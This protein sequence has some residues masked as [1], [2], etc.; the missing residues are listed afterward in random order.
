MNVFD[1]IV[2]RAVVLT[3][4]KGALRFFF[5]PK[6][7]LVNGLR[8]VHDFLGAGYYRSKVSVLTAPIRPVYYVPIEIKV[9]P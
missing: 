8:H 2:H 3:T 9:K 7:Q 4:D 5:P 1:V 6:T